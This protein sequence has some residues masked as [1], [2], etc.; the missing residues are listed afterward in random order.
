MN[1]RADPP[2]LL[3]SPVLHLSEGRAV[4]LLSVQ[5]ERARPDRC[6]LE[7]TVVPE[8]TLPAGLRLVARWP[9]GRRSARLDGAGC[10]RLSGIPLA[11]VQALQAGEAGALLVEIERVDDE[12][13]AMG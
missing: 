6:R 2:L 9:G 3:T 11:A 13:D 1:E 8:G 12:G 5:R 4:V 7:A 10:G